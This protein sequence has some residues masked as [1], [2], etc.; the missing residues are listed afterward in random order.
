MND[1]Q[2]LVKYLPYHPLLGRHVRHDPRSLQ[3]PFNTSRLSIQSAKHQRRIAVL[4]QGQLGSCTGNAGI[5]CMGTD[6]YWTTVSTKPFY[7]LDENGA[8]ALYS[9]ATANDDYPGQYPPDDTGCDGLTI[10]KTLQK[11]NM[12]SGYQHTFSTEDALK[13]LSI[14]SA[15]VGISW[16]NDMF[17]PD[18]DGRVHPTGSLA[19]GHEIVADEVDAENDR[20]WFTNSWGLNWGVSGRF[21]LTWDDFDHLLGQKG[22]VT[23]FTPNT[24]APPIP[25]PGPATSN[26]K[27]AL[28]L[29][30]NN[31]VNC[32]HVGDNKRVANAAKIW[33]NENAL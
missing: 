26:A 6:P 5:G 9:E 23:I 1:S 15:I 10:A 28:A 17:S 16:F 18:V 21:Y 32:R 13:A 11:H 22:D 29:H 33:L 27:F 24:V 12:I 3:Y 2:Y 8:V 30:A 14:T 20:V 25:T 7:S 4:D 19:G 31:W